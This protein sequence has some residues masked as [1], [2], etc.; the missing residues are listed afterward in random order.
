MRP[1]LRTTGAD[2][3]PKV[4]RDFG[5]CVD[6]SEERQIVWRDPSQHEASGLQSVCAV[7]QGHFEDF[8]MPLRGLV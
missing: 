1:T 5:K 3:R 6:A 7:C 4:L 8:F 2:L